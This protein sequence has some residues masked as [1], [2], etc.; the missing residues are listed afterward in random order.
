MAG[1]GFPWPGADELHSLEIPEGIRELV[2]RR[3]SRLSAD[4]NRTLA[5]AAVIGREFDSELLQTL[6]GPDPDVVFDHIDE[7]VAARI[8]S[9]R[10][11]PSGATPSRMP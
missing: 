8:S 7:A 2:G 3:L 10:R 11:R 4:T 9:K 5:T 1:P 6:H